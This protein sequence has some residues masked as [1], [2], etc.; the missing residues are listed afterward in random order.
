M[1]RLDLPYARALAA[2]V[3]PGKLAAAVVRRA[4]RAT[5][6]RGWYAAFCRTIPDGVGP[7]AARALER[8]PRLFTGAD[9]R[10][11]YRAHFPDA[12]ERFRRRAQPLLDREIDVFGRPVAL[13]ARID[14]HLDRLSGRRY[15]P[16]RPSAEIDLFAGGADPK[17]AW[18]PARAA[19][20]VE[21]GAAVR[22][23][24]DLG[25][26]GR[27][28]IRAQIESF[29]DDNPVGY[30][31]HFASPLEVAVRVIHWLGALELAGGAR[32]FPFGFIARLGRSLLEQGLFLSAEREDGAVVP[33]NHLIGD[34]VALA[35]LGLA[36][37]GTP[38]AASLRRAGRSLP[39]AAARQ[40]GADGAH[41]EAST[42]YHRFALELL[43]CAHLP[44]S[45]AGHDSGLGPLLRRMF[46][47]ASGILAPDGSDP[48]FGDGDDARMLPLV[49]RPPRDHAY[50]RSV[51]AALLG[52]ASLGPPDGKLHE[53]AL[54]WSG[55]A[56]FACAL[57]RAPQLPPPSQ[58]F[59]SGGVHLLRAPRWYVAFRSGGHG[60]GGVGGH[61]HNDQLSLVVHLDG[62]PLIIDSGT[63][64]Y[65]ADPLLRDRF[66]GTAAHS[67]V[68]VDGAEQSPLHPDRPFALPDDAPAPPVRLEELGEEA[69]L[70]G[71]HR[72]Y[73]RLPAR[74]RHQ[75]R[76]R[77][78][79][80]LNALL[81][82]D[83]LLGRGAAAIEVR[84]QLAAAARRVL[85]PELRARA[86]ALEAQLG[87]FDLD[88]A[89]EVPG[90]AALLPVGHAP[91]R[92]RLSSA[93]QSPRYATLA[94]SW[95]A[96]WEGRLNLPVD[97]RFVILPLSRP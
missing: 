51:G 32:A 33:A 85:S 21:L 42:A 20:L 88:E 4:W 44:L 60:Q 25:A 74:A 1:A 67:T 70:D 41:F 87:P 92:L 18:E 83:Q 53:E 82:E 3:P 91:L 38:G 43:L 5:I 6:R 78:L 36:L 55:P 7:V 75:R 52:D 81:I 90:L 47:F 9:L 84:F 26:A 13:G 19:H 48:G 73:L 86:A 40:V 93:V 22:L 27:A 66:R 58:S 29:L 46:A 49:P 96:S 8:A 68:V 77:L 61:A 76:L 10:G 14:W 35:V 23:Y 63:G 71:E 28:E 39:R 54:W 34:L 69:R 31:V 59:P 57:R 45:A 11:A 15:D 79:R 37:E 89:V 2:A 72:G 95:L 65:T 50:L 64:G 80:S 62:R 24:P 56:A 17:G 12:L 97:M 16:S 30:G 94:P